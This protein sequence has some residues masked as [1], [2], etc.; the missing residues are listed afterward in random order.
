[1]N[2]AFA[3]E[4]NVPIDHQDFLHL[5]VEVGV[6]LFQVV[7]NLVRLDV[8]VVQDAPDGAFARIGQAG[9]A[10]SLRALTNKP[11]QRGDRPQLGRQ[12][13][14]LGFGACDADHPSLGFVA[15]FGFM[16][17]MVFVLEPH[18]DTCGQRL[19]HASV[20]HR[21]TKPKSALQLRDRDA[22]SVA[23]HHLGAF[24]LAS[25]RH[26]R[27]SKFLER[28]PLFLRQHQR[29]PFRFSR[30]DH[31]LHELKKKHSDYI[32]LV[33]VLMERTTRPSSVGEIIRRSQAE[34]ARMATI[35]VF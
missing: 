18:L 29:R 12:P 13:M 5:S 9:K 6:A 8:V 3:V 10:G 16:W 4:R 14:I 33:T 11:C 17:P 21:S 23:Q 26:P 15:D 24:H 2:S 31:R 7:T 32:Y 27:C 19:V 25:G 30:H 20:D 34:Q 28:G 22:I 1:M 35:A